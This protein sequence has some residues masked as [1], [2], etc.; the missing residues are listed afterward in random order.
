M[1]RWGAG[2][3]KK[4]QKLEKP[5]ETQMK[6]EDTEAGKQER[7]ERRQGSLSF[8]RMLLVGIIGFLPQFPSSGITG[9]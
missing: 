4:K 6:V 1:T 5:S 2:V 8:A 3:E 7:E 9:L